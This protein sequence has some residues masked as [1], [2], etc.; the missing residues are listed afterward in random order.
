[1][2][3]KD[4][5]QMFVMYSLWMAVAKTL[6]PHLPCRYHWVA[7]KSVLIGKNYSDL[8]PNIFAP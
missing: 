7:R 4:N 3:I 1:M 5:L 2:F 8:E 6:V